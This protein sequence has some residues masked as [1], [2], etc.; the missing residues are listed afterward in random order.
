MW[1]RP[2][3]S[4]LS[5]RLARNATIGLGTPSA[6]ACGSRYSRHR[7]KIPSRSAARSGR[8]P[9]GTPSVVSMSC[10]SS[11]RGPVSADGPEL[12]S[13]NEPMSSWHLVLSRASR[14]TSPP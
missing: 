1:T 3:G 6:M 10:S 4:L 9:S 8:V 14:V 5:I 13:V 2:Y 11:A 7:P 12:I